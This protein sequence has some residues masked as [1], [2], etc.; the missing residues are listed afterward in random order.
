LDIALPMVIH[1]N[2][3]TV[4]VDAMKEVVD[5]IMSDDSKYLEIDVDEHTDQELKLMDD[6]CRIPRT[7][8]W[9]LVCTTKGGGCNAAWW[10]RQH[11]DNKYA[12]VQARF[13]NG[14]RPQI[15]FNKLRAMSMEEYDA[16]LESS[17]LCGNKA[18]VLKGHV[19]QESHSENVARYRVW[20]TNR[21]N[22]QEQTPAEGTRSQT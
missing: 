3:N 11:L 20:R 10:F 8:E 1:I 16:N 7:T 5:K 13:S 14:D 21:E 9:M 2:R 19:V 18:C 15:M 6:E 4:P 12:Q 17:H 22:N